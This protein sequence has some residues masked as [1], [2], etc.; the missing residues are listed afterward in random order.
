MT[1]TSVELWNR[2]GQRLAGVLHGEAAGPVVVSC[3]GMLSNK[4]GV[5]H[6]LL[7]D[8]LAELG[9]N[10][11]RFDFAGLGASEGRLF[12][13]TYTHEMEDLEAVL[14]FLAERGASAFGVFGSS[15]GGTVALLVAARD[16]RVRAVA[17]LA[18][19]GHPELLAE[20]HPAEATA[21]ETCG[22][23]ETVEGRIGRNLYDDARQH[24]LI[25]AVRV[26]TAP[27]LVVHGEQDE[28]VPVS[29]AHDIAAAARDVTLEVVH[30]ADH[31]FTA[32]VHL[33]PAMA[34]VA[35][36]LAQH[37]RPFA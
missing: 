19:V 20:R 5:K 23:I 28:V 21:F 30:G 37:L 12:D 24:D 15:M 3:H 11:L 33:Q 13:M 1:P 35:R 9:V 18:A 6:R 26:L 36:F 31:R 34:L 32:A 29:D 22:Y 7:A 8:G 4:D 27:L 16:E 2:R 25:A 10:C 14:Q 17:T